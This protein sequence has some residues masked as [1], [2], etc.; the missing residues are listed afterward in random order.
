[1]PT[2]TPQKPA[3]VPSPDA[4]PADDSKVGVPRGLISTHEWRN[5]T[6]WRKPTDEDLRDDKRRRRPGRNPPTSPWTGKP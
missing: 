2:E 5:G 6:L 1:M 4:P 3:T